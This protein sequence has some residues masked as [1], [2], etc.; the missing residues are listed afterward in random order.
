MVFETQSSERK[1]ESR[2]ELCE[3]ECQFAVRTEQFTQLHAKKR[4]GLELAVSGQNRNFI[5]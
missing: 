5:T 3:T 4:G 2:F 1:I